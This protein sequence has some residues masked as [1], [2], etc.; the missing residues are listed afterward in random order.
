MKKQN[1][2]NLLTF[3]VKCLKVYLTS[4]DSVK[5]NIPGLQNGK[6]KRNVLL[7]LL[8]MVLENQSLLRKSFQQY[9][10]FELLTIMSN[11]L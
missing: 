6:Q 4:S 5:Y 11:L 3:A 2:F 10:L 1:N 8:L 9:R 7:D